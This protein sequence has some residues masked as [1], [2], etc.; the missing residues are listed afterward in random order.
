MLRKFFNART[1]MVLMIIIGLG[2]LI[3]ATI[4]TVAAKE[5]AKKAW[6]GVQIQELTPSLREAMKLGDKTGLLITQVV[7]DSPADDANLRE[8]DVIIEFNG[9]AVE[10]ADAFTK[11]VRGT[12]PNKEVKVVIMRDGVRKEIMVTLAARKSSR[13]YSYAFSGPGHFAF[14]RVHLG[15]QT[16]ELNADLAAYF[17]VKEDGGALILN[18][19]E[20][21]PAEKAGLKAGDVITKI[22]EETV[23]DP[24]D[25]VRALSDY[26]EDDEITVTY[27]R[28][29]K[30][31]TAKATLEDS[32]GHGFHFFQAPRS[33]WP[34]IQMFRSG[35]DD[36]EEVIIAPR[37]ERQLRD[38]ER[39]VIEARER[40]RLRVPRAPRPLRVLD[41]ETI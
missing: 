36:D 23:E 41:R 17:N 21:T 39:A 30:T 29:G 37:I 13:S 3:L 35:D 4:Q 24:G 19:M 5:P 32:D 22:D 25:L 20:D 26:E 28:H 11:L 10:R 40:I 7:E 16:Q 15:V 38:A 33:G 2:A 31:A 18:V 14:S 6:L 12:E 8:E 34:R 9:Q 1:I 27:V